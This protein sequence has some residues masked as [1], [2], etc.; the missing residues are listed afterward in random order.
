MTTFSPQYLLYIRSDAWRERRRRALQRAGFR[1]QLC[2][3][4]RRLQVHHVTYVN[5]G[6]EKDEDLTALCWYCHFVTTWAIR[7][8]RFWRWF[9]YKVIKIKQ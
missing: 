1:C 6:N 7:L 3:E 9:L 8:R 4:T 5:L 2:G